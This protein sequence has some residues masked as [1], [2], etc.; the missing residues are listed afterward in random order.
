M[1]SSVSIAL[2]K[3][4]GGGHETPLVARILPHWLLAVSPGE[5]VARALENRSNAQMRTVND[6]DEESTDIR[7]E[8]LAG[9]IAREWSQALG[10]IPVTID[11]DFF[12]IGGHSL[13]IAEVAARVR[14]SS[15]MTIPFEDFFEFPTARELA[16]TATA[17][18]GLQDCLVVDAGCLPDAASAA[19]RLERTAHARG[20]ERPARP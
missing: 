7:V 15:G 17:N 4:V 19:G 9:L 14:T 5:Q 16:T 3:K 18:S 10:G 2:L 11:S 12:D 6:M 13:T 1:F 20:S 8:Q